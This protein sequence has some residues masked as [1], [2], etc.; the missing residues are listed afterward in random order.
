[1]ET[2]GPEIWKQTEGKITHFFAALGTCGTVTGTG[3]FLKSKNPAIQVIAIAP[4]E[5]HDVPGLRN[6]SQ[7]HVSKLF[8]SSV[9]DDILEI[10]FELAYERAL[11]LSRKEGLLA[12]PSS[13]LIFEGARQIAAKTK[14]GLGVMMFPDNIFK[15]LSSMVKHHPELEAE[16]FGFFPTA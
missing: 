11:D 2:T 9:V 13:G 12:G 14:S 7:L 1:M 6:I 16:G 3:R 10:D 8:D 15:Y 4:S 5:G